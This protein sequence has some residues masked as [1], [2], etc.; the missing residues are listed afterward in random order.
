MKA[1]K[2]KENIY[3]V[4][5]IDWDMREFHGYK[6][7]K[8]STY[9]AYLIIDEKIVLVDT[10]RNYL[11][12]EMID[13]IKSIIDPSKI[14]YVISNHSEMDHSGSLPEIMNLAKNATLVC[15]TN[16]EKNLRRHFDLDAWKL[17]VV[18]THD[19]INIGKRNLQF[20]LMQMVH[21]PD[22][23]ATYIKED[24][25]LLSN[26]AFG[27]HIASYERFEEEIGFD[28]VLHEAKKYYAN[29]LLAYNKQT[30]K[31]IN[32]IETLDIEM[33][34][35]SH[36]LI[37]QKHAKDI[38]K[39]YDYFSKD[40]YREKAVI[41][42]DTMWGSTKK[43]A[44]AIYKAFDEMDIHVE[45]KNLKTSHIS[46]IMTSVIDAKYICVGVPTLNNTMLPT[47]ASFMNYITGLAPQNRKAIVFGSHG[48]GGQGA[49][50]VEA[51]L[52]KNGFEILDFIT[53]EYV[54][55]ENKLSSITKK[56]K[57]ILS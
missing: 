56:V 31:A 23:M 3:W 50:E 6:T 52:K 46:D 20:V 33:I 8:G 18:K 29:I 54:P 41:I 27:Q 11:C 26:D 40:K 13:R 43:M 38:I 7:Q 44:L 28:I 49:K 45:L 4:G 34:A 39:A 24:K 37:W 21:W 30:Q 57:D 53:N 12:S 51:Q 9:N 16:G 14:D 48:W 35:P 15:S 32:E 36:G 5:V 2:I 22:S 1:K 17:K 19:E 55:D 42:Y 47:M 25:L 10:V